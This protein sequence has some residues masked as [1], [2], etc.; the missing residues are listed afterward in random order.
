VLAVSAVSLLAFTAGLVS[1]TAPAG[2]TAIQAPSPAPLITTWSSSQ[3]S[4]AIVAM[5]RPNQPN[6]TFWQLFTRSATG[7][8]AWKLATPPGVADN[9]G[10]VATSDAASGLT[11]G[12]VPSQLL[13]FSPLATSANGGRSWSSAVLPGGLE[14]VPD[15]LTSGPAGTLLALVRRG[16]GT[17]L[18]AR[19]SAG[20]WRAIASLRGL[21][22]SAAGRACDLTRLTAV[23]GTSA[24]PVV[25]GSCTAGGKVGVFIRRGGTWHVDGPSLS[26]AAAARPTTVLRWESGLS[27]TAGLV[28]SARGESLSLFA[29]RRQSSSA[30]WSV[31]N[32]LH[33]A[34][35]VI[36]TGINADGSI[37]V[38][39]AG[40]GARR[41]AWV[42]SAAPQWTPLP[43]LPPRTVAVSVGSTIGFDGAGDAALA[44][45]GKHFTSYGLTPA[46]TAWVRQATVTVP[47]QYGSST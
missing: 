18:A 26:G 20:H 37:V 17:V 14:N 43:P 34:G 41:E 4:S 22:G 21:A 7:S 29:L 40:T 30:P 46:G 8:T 33:P 19:G 9:G 35:R 42:M 28:A 12:V 27:G 32:A 24:T 5:G 45:S 10:L 13:T 2:A 23:A 38:V 47:L 16:G 25:A 31:S 3:G 36:S 1:P 15:A 6:N 39:T 44:V 11:A